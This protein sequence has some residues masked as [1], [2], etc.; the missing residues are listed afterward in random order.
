MSVQTV[1]I[2]NLDQ[3]PALADQLGFVIEM[4]R[5]HVDDVDSGLEDGMYDASDNEDIEEK[6]LA[7]NATYAL[8][9]RLIAS[10]DICD[11]VDTGQLVDMGKGAMNR[12]RDRAYRDRRLYL[13]MREIFLSIV[14]DLGITE[15]CDKLGL[16]GTAIKLKEAQL[17]LNATRED[18]ETGEPAGGLVRLVNQI[19]ALNIWEYNATDVSPFQECTAPT[20]GLLDSHCCLMGLVL[21]A[22]RVTT[23]P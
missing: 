19:A 22:R 11:G 12:Q 13:E 4:A 14:H 8:Q 2:V 20:E 16:N 21:V 18:E 17:L 3:T 7:L 23:M 1:S 5:S 15:A 9:G 6:R 10:L